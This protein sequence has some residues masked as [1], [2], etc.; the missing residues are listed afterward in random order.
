MDVV[1]VVD[2]L[3]APGTVVGDG[4]YRLLDPVGVDER[5]NAHLW[6]ARDGQLNRDVALTILRGDSSDPEAVRNTLQRVAP[7]TRFMHPGI[8]AVLNVLSVGDGVGRSEGI[9]GL[10]AAEW[11]RGTGMS[12]V[13]AREPVSPLHACLLLEP[14]AD[15]VTQAHRRG[16]M[17]GV[18]HPH[19]VR[20]TP[21]G[22]LRLAFPGP[23]AGVSLIDDVRGLAAILYFLLTG[24]WPAPGGRIVPPRELQPEVPAELSD[25][26]VRSLTDVSA[27]G[28]RTSDSIVQVL[29]Q[30]TESANPVAAP[31]DDELL[32]GTKQS[33]AEWTT[34]PPVNDAAR[35]KK[36]AI[37]VAVLVLISIG[38]V[39]WVGAMVI[40]T[41]L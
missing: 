3:L 11:T 16:V 5:D 30:V 32:P 38:V 9:V 20:V 6:R 8:A 18:G 33:G 12:D 10:V 21:A 36:L 2:G 35:K 34:K 40:G 1:R 17:L 31:D 24:R 23:P 37:A 29:R 25:V 22:R 27:G 26:V 19:R 15:A 41:F 4:R 39:V 28:I 13:V 7:A 14:L